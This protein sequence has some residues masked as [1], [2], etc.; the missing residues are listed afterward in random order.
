LELTFSSNLGL[1]ELP[2]FSIP[3]QVLVDLETYN[4]GNL[5]GGSIDGNVIT[6]DLN[7]NLIGQQNINLNFGLNYNQFQGLTGDQAGGFQGAQL[8]NKVV[9]Q[10]TT[11]PPTTSTVTT[12]TA[13][14]CPCTDEVNNAIHN[15]LTPFMAKFSQIKHTATGANSIAF[16]MS[17]T[18]HDA[19]NNPGMQSVYDGYL[20]MRK[21]A[22]CDA[23][24]LEKFADPSVN[25]YFT[26]LTCVGC[27]TTHMNG[28]YK[29][30]V[31][32]KKKTFTLGYHFNGDLTADTNKQN[33][34]D[35]YQLFVTGLQN[36]GV[37]EQQAYDCVA[38]AKPA[39]MFNTD[40]SCDYSD[41]V[42]EKI[43]IW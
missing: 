8:C 19:D 35:K 42:G 9:Q 37:T 34:V 32:N 40:G 25:W 1:V 16:A 3:V 14:P 39:N 24:V 10:T 17:Q 28:Y 22:S 6:L 26:D 4:Q 33:Q 30:D 11:E 12:T 36:L 2:G 31:S 41:C 5:D 18:I 13:D 27:Y 43:L 23:S 29:S 21:Y 20:V 7:S 15:G 38:G